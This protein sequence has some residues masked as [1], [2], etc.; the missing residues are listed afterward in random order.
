M[1]PT[2]AIQHVEKRY[3][4]V[5]ALRDVSFTLAPGRLSALVGHNGAGKTTLIKLMLGLIRPDQGTI[6]VLGEDPAAG[7]FAGRKS[8]GFLPENVAFNA[9]LTGRETMAFYARLKGCDARQG[10]AL[11]ERVGL[12]DASRRLVGTYS[13]G[14]RQRLGLA[15]ALLGRPRVLLL[16]EPTTGLDPALR[17]TFY[18]ILAEL[19]NDGATV[20]IS[21]HALN[22]LEDR[23]EQVLIMN[24]GVL[25]ADGALAELRA[26]SRLPIRI[27]L[28]LR[29]A[30]M[31]EWSP[32]DATALPGGCEIRVDDQVGKMKMLRQAANDAA[33]EDIAV[34]EPTLD[35]LYAHFLRAQEQ[36]A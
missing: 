7:Q 32:P 14:M 25:V 22:E 16:D 2:V 20:L 29:G 30:A 5:R 27:S 6:R 33:V 24:R 11:L 15:Q 19:R 8:L 28:K 12:G 4:A 34:A 13:K 35:E 10:V 26:L 23:A 3:R 17:Q 36:A 9:A 21:S 31:P 1:N 18:E